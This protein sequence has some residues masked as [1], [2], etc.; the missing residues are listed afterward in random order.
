M[1]NWDDLKVFTEVSKT[2]NLSKAGRLLDIDQTTVY[3]RI[4]R[5][6]KKIGQKLLKKTRQG[7]ILTPWGE[8]LAQKCSRLKDEIKEIDLFIENQQFDIFGK[9][10]ITTTNVIANVVLPPLLFK[11]HK[12]YPYLKI[13]LTVAEEFFDMYKREADLAIRSTDVIEPHEHAVKIGKGVWAFYA[14]KSYIENKPK[15]DSQD[16]FSKNLFVV[17]SGKIHNIKSTKYL[18]TKVDE[19]NISLKANS[20]ESVYA[21]V[22]AGLGIGLLPC[23]YKSI[24]S[25]LVELSEPDSRFS[26]P[27]WLI[28]QKEL[29]DTEKIRICIDYFYNELKSVF[30]Y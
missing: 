24:D 23:V 11:F 16:F 6:E 27:I 10:N 28:T 1:Y 2:L 29:A 15:M 25:S 20:M 5:L 4:S 9:V 22:K 13:E 3:R 21:G 26:S 7:Y 17:G 30:R 8:G 19:R 18:R 12:K 14:T